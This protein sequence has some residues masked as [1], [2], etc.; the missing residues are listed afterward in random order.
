MT[1]QAVI[2]DAVALI[3]S[4]PG[5]ARVA[6]DLERRRILFDPRLPDR[7]QASLGGTIRIGPETLHGDRDAVLVALAGTLVHE[8]H[9]TR[10]NPF[11]KTLSFWRGVF[12]RTHPMGRYE[13][14]AYEQ[15]SAFLD[16]LALSHPELAALAARERDAARASF[17]ACYGPLT[18]S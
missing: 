3:G 13:R 16:A 1:P 11:L 6:R 14:P 15:Q 7:G 9:H 4:V 5:Y 2:R 12:T 8:H 10:Q 17:A 18:L